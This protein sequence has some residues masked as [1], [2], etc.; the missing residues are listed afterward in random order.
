MKNNLHTVDEQVQ[1]LLGLIEKIDNKLDAIKDSVSSIANDSTSRLAS[2]ESW[3]R[4]QIENTQRLTKTADGFDERIRAIERE[5]VTIAKI[6]ALEARID[7][8]KIE[9]SALKEAKAAF[10]VKD[11]LVKWGIATI[12]TTALN[13]L[14]HYYWK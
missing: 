3:Q 5:R 1:M 7:A 13:A 12:V 10:G 2:L 4:S 8:S 11:S 14:M 6:E 9:I